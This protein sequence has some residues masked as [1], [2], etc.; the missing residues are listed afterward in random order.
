MESY[1]FIL[2]DLDGTLTDPKVGITKSA[3]YALKKMGIDEKNLDNLT[4]FIGPPLQ[5]SFTD[6]Y[7]FNKEQ[8]EPAIDYYRERFK[9]K[10]MFENKPYEGIAPLLQMF[11]EQQYTLVVATSKL[12]VFAEQILKHFELEQ[13]FDLV[14]GSNLDGTRSEKAEIIRYILDY[15]NEH[16]NDEFVMVGDRKYDII[17]ANETNIDSIAVG[18]GYGSMEELMESQPT[19]I[20]ESVEQLKELLAGSNRVI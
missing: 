3:Q 15:Y 12:T 8:T 9:E 10:G 16:S 19:Q 7:G 4:S 1:R 2:F 14:V 20:V 18:Y 13:Y 6:E 17:G 5:V 11:V